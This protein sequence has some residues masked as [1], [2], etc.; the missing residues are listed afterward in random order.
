[1]VVKL[2]F[3]P[4]ALLPFVAGIPYP[5]PPPPV[6]RIDSPPFQLFTG[7]GSFDSSRAAIIC[8]DVSSAAITAHW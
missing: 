2:S 8:G 7:H 6:F 4:L 3:K 1:M 5:P